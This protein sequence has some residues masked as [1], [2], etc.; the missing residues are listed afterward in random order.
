[1]ACIYKNV[2][3]IIIFIYL[4]ICF[5]RKQCVTV[6]VFNVSKLFDFYR[7]FFYIFKAI[8]WNPSPNN[9]TEPW[10]EC[11]PDSFSVKDPTVGGRWRGEERLPSVRIRSGAMNPRWWNADVARRFPKFDV[12]WHSLEWSHYG[13]QPFHLQRQCVLR[14]PPFFSAKNFQIWSLKM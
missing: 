1:M 6:H 13:E 2:C 11:H 9:I 4:F 12:S 14:R 10:A 7:N 3:K 8:K 5:S